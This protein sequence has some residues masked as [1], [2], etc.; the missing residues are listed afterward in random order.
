MEMCF[1]T[2]VDEGLIGG[3]EVWRMGRVMATNKFK[4][5]GRGLDDLIAGGVSAEAAPEVPARRADARGP[6][7]SAGR[8]GGQVGPVDAR[9]VRKS[10][11]PRNAAFPGHGHGPP[12]CGGGEAPEG[13]EDRVVSVRG[14][15]RGMKR[16]AGGR[17]RGQ[18]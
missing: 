10:R 7:R 5:L 3:E 2:G 1:G 15:Y 13:M 12:R 6:Y 18:K 14:D 9:A 16:A 11:R 17:Q 8:G 4:G